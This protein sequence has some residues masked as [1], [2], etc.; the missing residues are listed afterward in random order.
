MRHGRARYLVRILIL[1]AV[2]V[3]T[4]IIASAALRYN[5]GAGWFDAPRQASK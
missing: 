5:R 4:F 3:A 2:A 1:L